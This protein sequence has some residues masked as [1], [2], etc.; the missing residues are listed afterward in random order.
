MKIYLTD[1]SRDLLIGME[2][3]SRIFLWV[4]LRYLSSILS[5]LDDHPTCVTLSVTCRKRGHLVCWWQSLVFCRFVF[6]MH[7]F[8]LGAFLTMFSF[9]V[10]LFLIFANPSMS[11]KVEQHVTVKFLTWSG[12]TPI[13][14]WRSLK[15]V[16]GDHT[17]SK[18]QVRH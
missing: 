13:E 18:T 12:K 6:W 1:P 9:V 17:L 4:L 10:A 11:K 2:F 8:N 16:W 3:F 14:I 15:D 5:S 7:S